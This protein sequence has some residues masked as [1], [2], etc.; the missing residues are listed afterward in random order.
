MRVYILRRSDPPRALPVSNLALQANRQVEQAKAMLR[1]EEYGTAARGEEQKHG[2]HVLPHAAP[3][4]EHTPASSPAHAKSADGFAGA[5]VNRRLP[6]HVTI[7]TRIRGD[8]GGI[9][10]N[11]S[12]RL[13]H[14]SAA[15]EMGGFKA[16]VLHGGLQG[17]LETS[18]M[19]HAHRG[20]ES[21]LPLPHM[22]Y[23]SLAFPAAAV[24]WGGGWGG[25]G[26]SPEFNWF[27]S[28]PPTA[29]APPVPMTGGGQRRQ[30]VRQQGM[31]EGDA[32]DAGAAK[33]HG[34]DLVPTYGEE[35]DFWQQRKQRLAILERHVLQGMTT[36]HHAAAW[37]DSLRGPVHT[38]QDE[39]RGRGL[40]GHVM[41]PS[42][43]PIHNAGR[44]EDTA[45]SSTC[46][47]S[48]D[49]HSPPR[50]TRTHTSLT[51]SVNTT[52][53]ATSPMKAITP[54]ART[55]SISPHKRTSMMPDGSAAGDALRQSWP[56]VRQ[57]VSSSTC[58][59][60]PLALRHQ[61]GAQRRKKGEGDE[62]G[63]GGIR[64]RERHV[65]M[66]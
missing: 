39:E 61:G 38:T 50:N 15:G 56:P 18:D 53:T 29:Q 37:I 43:P 59:S 64:G 16:S 28:R 4:N 2:V 33:E 60:P 47:R 35:E 55:R 48:Q 44:D 45:R 49:T 27:G 25:G 26:V 52:S 3:A 32:G 19:F 20:H 12:V 34:S 1:G 36:T 17:G 42:A 9:P 57:Y 14:G 31:V 62:R 6:A 40:V 22:D 5:R 65:V 41:D 66:L 11:C 63:A 10:G 51:A 21:P 58:T 23:D 54:A 8:D 46:P 24:G 30:E 7:G 13:M